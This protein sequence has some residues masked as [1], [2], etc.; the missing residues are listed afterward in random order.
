M[1]IHPKD[2]KKAIFKLILDGKTQLTLEEILDCITEM[3]HPV[4]DRVVDRVADEKEDKDACKICFEAQ[5]DCVMVPCGHL[6]LC[7][8]CGKGRED[9]PCPFC[10]TNVALVIKVYRVRVVDSH[11]NWVNLKK[12]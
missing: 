2:I 8:D 6:A 12:L 11:I 4:V 10:R 9:S 3:N 5:A 7:H 1:G